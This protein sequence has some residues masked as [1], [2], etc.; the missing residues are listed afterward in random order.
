M[1]ELSQSRFEAMRRRHY[2]PELNRISA[3]L[4][5]FHALP[6]TEGVRDALAAEARKCVSFPMRLSGVRSLG[7]GVAFT[8]DSPEL[9]AMRRRLAAVFEQDLNAQDR[10]GFRPHVVVQNKVSPQ[11]AKELLGEL[12]STFV[13]EDVQATGLGWWNYLGGPW[14]LR[15]IFRFDGQS[16]TSA[17]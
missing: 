5:L 6:A 7:R 15:Q 10:Q 3:H 11:Q 2:P 9:T 14:E 4:T 13:A 16:E 17:G 12:A 8:L 1:D